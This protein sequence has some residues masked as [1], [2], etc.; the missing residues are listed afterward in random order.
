MLSFLKE[1]YSFPLVFPTES[2]ERADFETAAS[3]GG[4]MVLNCCCEKQASPEHSFCG[5]LSWVGG[6]DNG[7]V[8]HKSVLSFPGCCEFLRSSWG[9]YSAVL[10]LLSQL[11][12]LPLCWAGSA[13]G[14]QTLSKGE[15]TC[16]LMLEEK[17]FWVAEL[18][19]L[20]W[21]KLHYYKRCH[22]W[23][24]EDLTKQSLKWTK[25]LSGRKSTIFLVTGCGTEWFFQC[26]HIWDSR[27]LSHLQVSSSVN[28]FFSWTD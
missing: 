7:S 11:H 17:F 24:F 13:H 9:P 5:V 22:P 27:Q 6:K 10:Q 8:A 26:Y 1:V 20:K 15:K 14:V 23:V 12:D 28:K 3:H 18:V 2:Q 21:Q 25:N 4:R 16:S 19:H